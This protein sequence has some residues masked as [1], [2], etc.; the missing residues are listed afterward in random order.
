MGEPAPRAPYG[1]LST[2][3][4]L[5]AAFAFLGVTVSVLLVGL[6]FVLPW[7]HLRLRA[8]GAFANFLGPK[9]LWF[10]GIDLVVEG[11][12]NAPRPAV[13]VINH[14]SAL[15]AP[16]SMAVYPEMA[17]GIGK[18][19]VI[20]VP[21][22]GAAYALTG[23]LLIDRSDRTSSIEAINGLVELI[24]RLG[25]SLWIAPEG[26]RSL[27]G[28]L[29]P[30][31]KGFVHIAIATGLPCVPVVFH[32]AGALWPAKT[33]RITPG[34][35]RVQVL[36]PVETTDWSADTLDEHVA[37]VRQVFVDALK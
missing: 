11:D 33:F 7:R 25:L 32:G 5:G 12:T 31:K 21:F 19:E 30:F 4:R 18:R 20:W 37:E 3:A 6:L 17:C 8:G 13:Y 16:V 24:N 22:F 2:W 34:T 35:V 29:L 28:A 15:D 1:A 9:L 23:N 26:T 36:D 14:T 10:L 27:D